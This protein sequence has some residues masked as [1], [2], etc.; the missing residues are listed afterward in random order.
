MNETNLNDFFTI[1]GIN[2]RSEEDYLEHYGKKGMRWGV[3]NKK[4]NNTENSKKSIAKK[5]AKAIGAATLVVGGA[6]AAKKILGNTGGIKLTDMKAQMI[7]KPKISYKSYNK[8]AKGLLDFIT[9][10]EK[11]LNL[12]PPT[13]ADMALARNRLGI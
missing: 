7:N 3:R 9:N 10:I 2:Q 11:E 4:I 12:S 13:L 1:V 8:E 6:Y 5:T